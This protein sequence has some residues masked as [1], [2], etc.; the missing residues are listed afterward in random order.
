MPTTELLAVVERDGFIE[1]QHRGV[2]VLIDPDGTV[3]E[4]HGDVAHRQVGLVVGEIR[5][6]QVEL[7]RAGID[8]GEVGVGED[9]A[10]GERRRHHDQAHGLVHDDGG[11]GGEPEHGQQERE[12][13]L[14]SPQTDET[15]Q[16]ADDGAAREPQ[17]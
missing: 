5:G 4:A 7:H 9:D 13:E 14:S 11:K 8:E 6:T 2:A 15:T 17:R 1:S 10:E 16:Q 12:P 3:I